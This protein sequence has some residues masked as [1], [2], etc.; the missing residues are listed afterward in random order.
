MGFR[1]AAALADIP[2]DRGL[3]VVID[4]HEI[5][6]FLVQGDVRAIENACPHAGYPLC[7][8]PFD[9]TVVVCPAHGWE[10]DLRTGASPQDPGTPLIESYPVRIEDGTVYVYVD[11]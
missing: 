3:R 5:G 11:D 1:R 2:A 4:E 6:L 8:G 10:F 9:G 7:Q